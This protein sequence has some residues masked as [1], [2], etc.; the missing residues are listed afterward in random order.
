MRW[1]SQ[2]LVLT[3]AGW[4]GVMVSPHTHPA[5]TLLFLHAVMQSGASTTTLV[6]CQP[7]T[8][9]TRIRTRTSLLHCKVLVLATPFQQHKIHFYSVCEIASAPLSAVA[10]LTRRVHTICLEAQNQDQHT[11][12]SRSNLCLSGHIVYLRPAAPP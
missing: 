2:D 5:A 8:P 7:R 9:V 12:L 1:V 3:R 4:C 10:I 11:L 6:P